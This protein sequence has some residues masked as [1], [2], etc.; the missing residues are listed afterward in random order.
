MIRSLPSGTTK[1]NLPLRS[2]RV[3]LVLFTDEN[4]LAPIMGSES[5]AEITEPFTVMFWACTVMAMIHSHNEIRSLFSILDV[6]RLRV[7][8]PQK[9]APL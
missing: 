6:F 2:V 3:A 1:V 9:Y 5:V 7:S 4:T 8:M